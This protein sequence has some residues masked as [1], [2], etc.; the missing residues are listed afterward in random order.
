MVNNLIEHYAHSVSGA[1]VSEWQ[2]LRCHLEN[3]AELADRFTRRFAPGWGRIAGLW[4]DSGKYRRS[5]QEYIHKD[6]DA[7]VSSR[8]DHS[9]VGALIA[10]E[11]KAPMVA[12]VV[13]GHHGGLANA[14][15][16]RTRL[17]AKRALLQEARDNGLPPGIEDQKAVIPHWLQTAEDHA[18]LSLWTRLLFSALVDADFLDT[19][20]FYAGGKER[21]LGARSSLGDLKLRLDAYLDRK[22]TGADRT[23]VNEMRARVLDDCRRAAELDCGA[24]TL[25]VPTGGGKTLASLAFALDHAVRHELSR[26]IVVIPYTSIIEQT[27]KTYREALGTTR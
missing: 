4:H 13:A 17:E 11:R 23:T 5:F 24:F 2:K 15:D 1:P 7:H 27:A 3:T 25:T 8:V 10:K 22:F 9:S 20:R 6:P 21:E 26:V 16:L 19:E 12:F 18:S 14:E